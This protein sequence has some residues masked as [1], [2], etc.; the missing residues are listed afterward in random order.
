MV[1]KFFMECLIKIRLEYMNK[2]VNK[3]NVYNLL[4]VSLLLNIKFLIFEGILRIN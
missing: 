4:L 1:L 3:Y 2:C